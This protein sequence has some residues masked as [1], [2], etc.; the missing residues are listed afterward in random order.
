VRQ[1][2]ESIYSEPTDTEYSNITSHDIDVC[3]FSNYSYERLNE[4]S[5]FMK[6]IEKFKFFIISK[7]DK[8]NFNQYKIISLEDKTIHKDQIKSSDPIGRKLMYNL[9][10]YQV[11]L[12]NNEDQIHIDLLAYYPKKCE[13][14]YSLWNN[15]YDVNSMY[16]TH[17]GIS[18]HSKEKNFF[19]I[20]NSI[21]DRRVTILYP[22]EEFIEKI[23]KSTMRK[24]K[25]EIYNQLI[26]FVVYRT[27]IL[28]DGYD[29]VYSDKKMLDFYIEHEENC[30]ITDAPP[31]YITIRLECQHVLSIMALASIVNVIA[32]EYTESI[33]CPF[34]RESLIPNL[35]EKKP[36]KIEVPS[37]SDLDV[38][39]RN[40]VRPLD[41]KNICMKDENII[42]I[43]GLL[44]GLH[45]QE[46][47][48][49]IQRVRNRR[50]RIDFFFGSLS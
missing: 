1:F 16:I 5:L 12:E 2:F 18:L 46:I 44:Q 40:K 26:Y 33:C 22:F 49:N 17:R 21:M 45:S 4:S 9:P 3:V 11:I 28:N 32:S 34:C 42:R 8:F 15:D 31:P 43:S 20:Q 37:F 38:S 6:M 24:N 35:I 19:E 7:D 48:E 10:H 39:N 27:K 29:E 14:M 30:S 25:V 50:E 41:K 23:K 36:P 47:N 13:D